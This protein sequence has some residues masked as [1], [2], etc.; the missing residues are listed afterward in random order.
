MS[1]QN[2][3]KE[4]R[5]SAKKT[6]LGVL[7]V[8]ILLNGCRSPAKHRFTFSGLFDSS[9][10]E[11]KVRLNSKRTMKK[12]KNRVY[13][14]DGKS[15]EL[16]KDVLRVITEQERMI[17]DL[18]G[19]RPGNFSVAIEQRIP[20]NASYII[21]N[22]PRGWSV[23]PFALKDVH[24]VSH[25]DEFDH[26]YHTMIHERTES[27]VIKALGFSG[28]GLYNCNRSTRWIGDG[29]A[30][31]TAYRFAKTHSPVAALYWLLGR[32]KAVRQAAEEW[33]VSR[34]NLRDFLAIQG[35]ISEVKRQL[36]FVQQYGI[37]VVSNYGMSFYYWASLADDKGLKTVKEIVTSLK[38]HRPTNQNIDAVIGKTVGQEYVERIENLSTREALDFFDREIE[39]LMPKVAQQL[40]SE[41]RPVRM[42]A[43]E[44][45]KRAEKEDF[46][47]DFSG[48]STTAMIA[49]IVPGTLAY[50]AGLRRYDIVESIDGAAVRQFSEVHAKADVAGGKQMKVKIRRKG[51]EVLTFNIRSFSGCRFSQIAN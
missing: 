2:R 8:A 6:L 47:V 10:R 41:K 19:I 34:C 50:K 49:N 37:F 20:E 1:E 39:R 29:L 43:F 28:K 4:Y 14:P 45:L 12:G 32:R 15:K 22:Q 18:L 5:M 35:S 33:S 26:L 21:N 7:V 44:A 40:K 48:I 51:T 36:A 9:A 24:A 13:Y 16:A 46:P 3:H 31:F 25:A 27:A 42:A 11:V 30:E 23:W 17:K 38:T